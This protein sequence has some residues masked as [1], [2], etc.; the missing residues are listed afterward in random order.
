MTFSGW[1]Q[2]I[3]ILSFVTAAAWGLG[4]YMAA[5]FSGQRTVLTPLLQPVE[6]GLARF[7]GYSAA[8]EQGWKAYTLAMLAFNAAGFVLLYALLRLQAFLPLN[9][10]GFGAVP[11]DL[12]FNTAI[13]FV[14]NTNW[15][16]YSGEAAMSH[17]VQMAGFTVH[18]FLSAATGIW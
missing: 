11:P 3:A 15:Q 6:R 5:L 14:T 18:N 8:A 12:S 13:S 10:Q 7:C 1:L 9:P 16:A 17:L 2:I 4:R